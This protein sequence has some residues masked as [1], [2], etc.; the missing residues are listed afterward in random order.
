[1]STLGIIVLVIV[2]VLLGFFI[3]SVI[4]YAK[5]GMKVGAPAPA[6]SAKLLDG[7]RISQTDWDRPSRPLLLCFMSP[8]CVA[9]RRLAPFLNGLNREYPDADLDVLILGINGSRAD[10][11]RW[12]DSLSLNL[13]V[14]VDED[15]TTRQRYSVY[16]LPAGFLISAGGVVKQTYRGYRAGDDEMFEA[17]FRERTVTSAARKP[18]VP[19]S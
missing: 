12:R 1:V 2:S 8:R 7:T 3:N 4:Y 18:A 11:K 16:S 9:C 15:G 5:Q 13:Q 10:F 19:V 14:A 6:F 17:L